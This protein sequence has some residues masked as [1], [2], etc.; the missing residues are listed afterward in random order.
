MVVA[1]A[2][3]EGRRGERVAVRASAHNL[4]PVFLHAPY[5]QQEGARREHG[6][7]HLGPMGEPRSQQSAEIEHPRDD[8]QRARERIE[9]DDFR[10]SRSEQ[11]GTG[12]ERNQGANQPVGPA[13][14][15]TPVSETGIRGYRTLALLA[16]GTRRIRVN[17]VVWS[18]PS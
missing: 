15:M 11:V 6:E 18:F 13:P 17:R 10:L 1:G 14:L 8:E 7:E 5:G 4:F 9:T 3:E 2:V 16:T 12:K